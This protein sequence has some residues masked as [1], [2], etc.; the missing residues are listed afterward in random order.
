MEK[1]LPPSFSCFVRLATCMRDKTFS[2]NGCCL[3]LRVMLGVNEL[4]SPMDTEHKVKF[5]NILT[6]NQVEYTEHGAELIDTVCPSHVCHVHPLE[7]DALSRDVMG[8]ECCMMAYLVRRPAPTYQPRPTLS[9]QS[10][11][12][13]F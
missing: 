3:A 2:I 4:F 7:L 13:P 6:L 10:H 1:Y 9:D 5:H 11:P 8:G 12:P